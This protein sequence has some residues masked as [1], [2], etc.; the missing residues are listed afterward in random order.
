MIPLSYG[1]RKEESCLS[2]VTLSMKGEELHEVHS[3]SMNANSVIRLDIGYIADEIP[4]Q[5]EI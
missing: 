5:A 4:T 3:E 2:L 1:S